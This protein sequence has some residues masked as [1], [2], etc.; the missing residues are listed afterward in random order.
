MHF[1]NEKNIHRYLKKSS[2]RNT[3]KR[4]MVDRG[5]KGHGDDGGCESI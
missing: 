1:R 3:E 5:D 2:N 4:G